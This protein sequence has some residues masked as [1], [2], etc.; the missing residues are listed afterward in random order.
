MFLDSKQQI[1]CLPCTV[2]QKQVTIVHIVSFRG[3]S[4]VF[5]RPGAVSHGCF[6]AHRNSASHHSYVWGHMSR[7][8]PAPD[9]TESRSASSCLARVT[10]HDKDMGR[11]TTHSTP[12]AVWTV[13]SRS[14]QWH[15]AHKQAFLRHDTFLCCHLFG[16]SLDM[17]QRLS[18]FSSVNK[19]SPSRMVQ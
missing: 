15:C 13:L 17:P 1:E 14:C 6:S 7:V 2:Y 5:V 10:S 16:R 19:D 8:V 11:G 18:R 9:V 12:R 3:V 4:S